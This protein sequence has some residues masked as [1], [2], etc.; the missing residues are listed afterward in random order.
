MTLPAVLRTEDYAR[1]WLNGERI[2]E[3]ESSLGLYGWARVPKSYPLTLKLKAGENRLLVKFTSL[4]S[5]HGL[6][7]Q[8]PQLTG[9]TA[10]DEKDMAAVLSST[11][12]RFTPVN[13][14]IASAGRT[15]QNEIFWER[16]DGIW[17]GLDVTTSTQAAVLYDRYAQ[18]LL[19]SDRFAKGVDTQPAANQRRRGRGDRAATV[20]PG[21]AFRRGS[22]VAA[23]LPLRRGADA[24]V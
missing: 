18:S 17:E 7:F 11:E 6:A 14:P 16:K 10:P 12:D 9:L 1:V 8:F 2:A 4:H 24:D 13:Q 23:I 21:A 5:A 15:A 19:R 20:S 22:G 3:V